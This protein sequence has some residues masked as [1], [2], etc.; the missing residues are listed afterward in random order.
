LIV[1]IENDFFSCSEIYEEYLG[2][3]A[4]GDEKIEGESDI[5]GKI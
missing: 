3:T 5:G 2:G 1:D 4:V